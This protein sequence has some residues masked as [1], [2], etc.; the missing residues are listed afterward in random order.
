MR[1]II[2]DPV[3]R[4]HQREGPVLCTNYTKFDES[5]QIDSLYL[6]LIDSIRM[7]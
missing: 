3:W 4:K 1:A 7:L 5:R 6:I 2:I